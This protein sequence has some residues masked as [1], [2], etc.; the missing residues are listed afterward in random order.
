MWETAKEEKDYKCF[1][2]LN[3]SKIK[4]SII[5]KEKLVQ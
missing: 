5:K 4:G 1:E 2:I 3:I